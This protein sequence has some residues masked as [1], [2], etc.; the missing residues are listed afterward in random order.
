MQVAGQCEKARNLQIPKRQLQLS[1][2]FQDMNP[3][4][5]SLNVQTSPQTI[6]RGGG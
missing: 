4:E 1:V 2:V 3:F 5:V 6:T